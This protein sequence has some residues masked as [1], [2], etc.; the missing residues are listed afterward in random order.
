ML[1]YVLKTFRVRFFQHI[2]E[3]ESTVHYFVIGAANYVNPSQE[4][5]DKVKEEYV[6]FFWADSSKNG[7]FASFDVGD[8]GVNVT[9]VDSVGE[10]LHQEK[11]LP[12]V[13]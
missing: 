12:R 8:E 7:G 9:L 11:L 10:E 6:K 3:D 4:H 5:A 13:L 1:R 2:K